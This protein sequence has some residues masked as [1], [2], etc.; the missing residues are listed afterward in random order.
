M[1][2][3]EL[4]IS[5]LREADENVIFLNYEDGSTAV[6]PTLRYGR[7]FLLYFFKIILF[8]QIYFMGDMYFSN[9]LAS[10]AV[11]SMDYGP[12]LPSDITKLHFPFCWFQY[13]PNI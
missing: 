5:C 6:L 1:E 11:R 2:D 8:L 10:P 4:K 7:E 12:S 13:L 9:F 3:R